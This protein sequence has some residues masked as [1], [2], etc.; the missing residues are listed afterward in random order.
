MIILKGLL[1][2]LSFVLNNQL[3]GRLILHFLDPFF[4]YLLTKILGVRKLRSD[5]RAN[6]KGHF[7]FPAGKLP[8]QIILR[9]LR[10]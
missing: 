10:W 7:R 5:E 3:N 6:D 2:Y 8:C 1:P 4:F 9:C